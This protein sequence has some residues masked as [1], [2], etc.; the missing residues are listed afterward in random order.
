MEQGSGEI[1]DAIEQLRSQLIAVQESSR[2]AKLRFTVTEVEMEF[3]VEVRKGGGA[4]AG[5]KLGLV[6][7]GAG[8]QVS[9]GT[10]HRLKVK[11]DARDAE[12]GDQAIVADRR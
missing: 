8:G 7:V 9:A 1:A 4:E 12:T 2:R 6:S 10:T 11:L 3:L 5:I